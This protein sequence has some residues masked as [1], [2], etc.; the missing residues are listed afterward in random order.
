MRAALL[1]NRAPPVL[2]MK[3]VLKA[4]EGTGFRVILMSA[5]LDAQ[6]FSHYFGG[7][8]LVEVPSAPRFPVQEHYLEDL[9]SLLQ[10]EEARRHRSSTDA[11]ADANCLLILEQELAHVKTEIENMQD[12]VYHEASEVSGAGDEVEAGGRAATRLA[13]L[14]R[15]AQKLQVDFD[16]ASRR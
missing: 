15:L 10:G 4:R 12:Q 5:T 1:L 16:D 7:A 9:P 11:K 2:L 14:Q 3:D 13:K 8:P 6:G